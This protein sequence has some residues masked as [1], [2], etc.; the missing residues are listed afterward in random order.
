MVSGVAINVQEITLILQSI[1]SDVKIGP[2]RAHENILK[3]NNY[4]RRYILYATRNFRIVL[5]AFCQS[6]LKISHQQL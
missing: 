5:K 2:A 3:V 4:A 1:L 6:I